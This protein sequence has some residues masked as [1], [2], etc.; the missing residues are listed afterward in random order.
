MNS[1]NTQGERRRKEHSQICAKLIEEKHIDT[2]PNQTTSPD[3]KPC[4]VDGVC[5]NRPF[6][7]NL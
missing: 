5:L 4:K 2:K 1:C 6:S 7:T 3:A